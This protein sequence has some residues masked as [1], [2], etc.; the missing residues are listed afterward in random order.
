MGLPQVAM[1]VAM[2][3]LSMWGRDASSKS[4]TQTHTQEQKKNPLADST[5]QDPMSSTG[6]ETP[7]TE[8]LLLSRLPSSVITDYSR[9]KASHTAGCSFGLP[10][11]VIR[12]VCILQLQRFRMR[13]TSR[14]S[15]VHQ[16]A[17]KQRDLADDPRDE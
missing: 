2:C 11:Q 9:Q 8:G 5:G 7:G 16:G 15:S 13:V 14:H 1:Q 12:P 3:P 17:S 4:T 6:F 10:L